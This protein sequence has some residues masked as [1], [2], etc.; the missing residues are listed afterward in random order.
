LFVKNIAK[1][2]Q[3][4]EAYELTDRAETSNLQPI[5][6]NF[7]EKL[8]LTGGL[9]EKLEQLDRRETQLL[10]EIARLN[11]HNDSR[12][13]LRH[14][15]KRQNS[16]NSS[17]SSDKRSSPVDEKPGDRTNVGSPRIQLL[18][19]ISATSMRCFPATSPIQYIKILTQ[20]VH[21]MWIK[22]VFSRFFQKRRTNGKNQENKKH[23]QIW[24]IKL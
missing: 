4:S 16:R 5:T 13:S 23:D 21:V 11:K 20:P 24:L 10:A 19:Y 9:K 7:Q 17:L 15:N 22:T 3:K 6:G 14:K 2:L 1:R 18:Y 12:H 8:V